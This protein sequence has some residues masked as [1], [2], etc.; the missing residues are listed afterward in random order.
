[1]SANIDLRQIERDAYRSTFQDGIW[2]IH[3]G[4]L[5]LGFS[6]AP[7]LEMIGV[8]RPLNILSAVILPLIV[9]YYGKRLIT[10]PRMGFVKFGP[11]RKA[12]GKKLRIFSIILTVVIITQI[13]LTLSG[14]FPPRW[15]S[16]MGRYSMPIIFALFAILIFSVVAYFRDFPRLVGI[17]ILFGSSI[18]LTE[19]LHDRLGS[20]L[21]SLIGFGLPALIILTMGIILMGRFIRK[22]PKPNQS[23]VADVS[24]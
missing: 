3:I 4:L 7:L 10:I 9:L 2:D 18:M 20:P 22:Y 13:I 21:A 15:M 1:M 24:R 6:T 16:D 14:T 11:K 8:V 23:E 5:L 12:A 19:I 17:G